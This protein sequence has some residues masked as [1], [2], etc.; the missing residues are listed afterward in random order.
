MKTFTRLT[1]T[2]RHSSLLSSCYGFLTQNLKIHQTEVTYSRT[3][4][5]QRLAPRTIQTVCTLLKDTPVNVI[6]RSLQSTTAFVRWGRSTALL[7]GQV[8]QMAWQLTVN[9]MR[10]IIVHLWANTSISLIYS[11]WRDFAF[12]LHSYSCFQGAGSLGYYNWN[13]CFNQLEI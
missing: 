13:N 8:S 2:C 6:S 4:H 11:F 12:C 10:H 7:C 1:Q 3:P 5:Q 9:I